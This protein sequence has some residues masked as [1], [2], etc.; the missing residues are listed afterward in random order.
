MARPVRIVIAGGGTGGHVFPALAIQE[1]L[2]RKLPNAEFTFV[3]TRAGVEW[4]ILRERQESLRTLWI[5]GFKRGSRL[6]NAFVLLKL[7]VSMFQSLW[8]LL[9]LRPALVIGTGGYVMGPILLVAQRLGFPTLLQEQNSVPGLTTRKLAPRARVVC[10]GL[11]TARNH[12]H[13]RRIVHTGNPIRQSFLEAQ[14][15]VGDVFQMAPDRRV[16]LVTGGSQGARSIN[17]AVA[18]SLGPLLENWNLIWQT[19][20]SGI[21]EFAPTELIRGAAA[22]GNLIVQ[23]FIDNMPGAYRAADLAVCRAGAMTIA[24]LSACGLP[25]VFVPFPFATD[26]HQTANAREL[27][28]A[29]AAYMI[30]DRDL[31]SEK[32]LAV[33]HDCLDNPERLKSMRSAMSS[34]ARPD[35]ADRIASLAAEILSS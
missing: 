11:E 20:R 4:R 24:E 13:S 23:P 12:L 35:A 16:I 22:N 3:G 5:S 6:Q 14:R 18:D 32:L 2:K 15:T 25:A 30:A 10:L 1:A 28:D 33:I 34:L 17:Q 31:N 19:G 29:G 8:I 27:I 7:L 9:T 26:D 21:P